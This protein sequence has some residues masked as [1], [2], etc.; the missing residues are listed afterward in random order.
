MPNIRLTP[1]F[2]E[3]KKEV[4][5][6][7]EERLAPIIRQLRQLEARVANPESRRSK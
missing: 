2:A 5:K 7:I 4:E 6:L 3:M 1:E